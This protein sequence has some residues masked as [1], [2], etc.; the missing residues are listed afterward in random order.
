MSFGWAN[1]LLFAAYGEQAPVRR[2][3]GPPA[4]EVRPSGNRGEKQEDAVQSPRASLESLRQAAIAQTP[5]WQRLTLPL[6]AT[7]PQVEIVL[8]LASRERRPPRQT[9]VLST[10]DASVVRVQRAQANVQSPAQR[11][12]S[13]M[14][15][16]HTGE[17]YGFIGQTIAGIASLAACVLV[18]PFVDPRLRG[19]SFASEGGHGLT[20]EESDWFWRTYAGSDEESDYLGLPGLSPCMIRAAPGEVQNTA[21]GNT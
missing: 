17:Q 7:G 18:Y 11:A 4:A 13:W 9:V 14:R 16:A 10:A 1:T 12:R 15:F 21:P 19:E 20:R 5:G 3:A 8:E 2:N 6:A